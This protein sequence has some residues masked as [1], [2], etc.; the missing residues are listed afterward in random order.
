M[1]KNPQIQSVAAGGAMRFRGAT[2]REVIDL[3]HRELGPSAIIV[4]LKRVRSDGLGRIWGAMELEALVQAPVESPRPA[5][6]EGSRSVAPAVRTMDFLRSLGLGEEASRNLRAALP[7]TS[8]G[9]DGEA[10]CLQIGAALLAAWDGAASRLPAEPSRVAFIGAPGIGKSAAMA[11]WI[12]VEALRHHRECRVWCLDGVVANSAG[13]L[14]QHAEL[15]GIEV[16]PRWNPVLPPL[17]RE[18]LDLPGWDPAQRDVSDRMAN[19]LDR[20]APDCLLLA[21]NAAYEEPIL[22]EQI[23]RFAP[24][25]PNGLLLTHLDECASPTKVWNLVLNGRLAVFATS[26]GRFIPGGL[27]RTLGETW[28]ERLFSQV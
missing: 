20:F 26:S 2:A 25:G 27:E 24:L 11:K 9:L 4:E 19:L 1:Q 15:L 21:L 12:T 6:S 17:A 3:V 5:G 13:F 14:A 22:R 7:P 16:E 28:M 23:R 10:A 18:F 8:D